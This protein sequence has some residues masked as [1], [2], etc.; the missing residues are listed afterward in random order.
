MQLIRELQ[1]CNQFVESLPTIWGTIDQ[2]A[3]SAE[4]SIERLQDSLGGQRDR[5]AGAIDAIVEERKQLSAAI[6][7]ARIEDWPNL[8]AGAAGDARNAAIQNILLCLVTL[9]VVAA[10][11]AGLSFLVQDASGGSW[12]EAVTMSVG[13]VTALSFLVVGNLAFNRLRL[14]QGQDG[15]AQ[16]MSAQPYHKAVALLLLLGCAAGLIWVSVVALGGWG[17]VVGIF[18]TALGGV[19]AFLGFGIERAAR[20]LVLISM[21]VAAFTVA[22]VTALLSIA[23]YVFLW[24]LAALAWLLGFVIRVLAKPAELAI[25]ALRKRGPTSSVSSESQA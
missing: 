3:R 7:S 22:A 19:L 12:P 13:I 14:V 17:V 15:R 16:P 21:L 10:Y 2:K 8:V 20:G 11:A 4:A 23:R 25:S 5:L 6:L 18:L 24:V 1:K 9:V